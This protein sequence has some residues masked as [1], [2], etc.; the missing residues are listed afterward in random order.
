[1]E[2]FAWTEKRLFPIVLLTLSLASP[3]WMIFGE[4][5]YRRNHRC[6]RMND[7]LQ[8]GVVIV[9]YVRRNAIHEGGIHDIKAFSAPKNGR[10]ALAIYSLPLLDPLSGEN[11]LA[12]Q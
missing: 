6:C 9:K 8:M 12:F 4:R 10:L 3:V 7:R 5:K 1:M 2:I 11:N